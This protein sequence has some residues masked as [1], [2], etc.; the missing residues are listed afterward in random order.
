MPGAA[1]QKATARIGAEWVNRNICSPMY[2]VLVPTD[3]EERRAAFEKLKA[4]LGQWVS[5]IRGPLYFGDDISLVDIAAFP[6]I[7]RVVDCKL[8]E[9]FRGWSLDL[10]PAAEQKLD[11]WR[12]AMLSLPSV[13][14]TLAEPERLRASYV[15]YAEG[16]AMSKVA[17]AVRQGASAHEEKDFD[18]NKRQ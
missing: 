17:E 1:S 6:W 15:R 12:M 9:T 14:A 7:Y 18:P 16:T 8:I 13:K 2:K 5:E 3:E 10:E 11:A 4:N